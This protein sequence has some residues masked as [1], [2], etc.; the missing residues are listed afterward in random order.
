M[1]AAHPL[2]HVFSFVLTHTFFLKRRKII[3]IRSFSYSSFLLKLFETETLFMQICCSCES[4][5]L[6][7]RHSCI[8][9]LCRLSLSCSFMVNGGGSCSSFHYRKSYAKNLSNI[10]KNSIMAFFFISVRAWEEEFSLTPFQD[11]FLKL[12]FCLKIIFTVHSFFNNRL[13]ERVLLSM[14]CHFYILII[15]FK[16]I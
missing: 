2:P 1:W 5:S 11:L 12:I 16:R 13:A 10:L 14:N 3:L 8:W 15:F 7:W 6:L 9:L 4:R